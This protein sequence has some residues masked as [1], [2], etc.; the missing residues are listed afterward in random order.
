MALLP[1]ILSSELCGRIERRDGVMAGDG[2]GEEGE[3]EEEEE[4]TMVDSG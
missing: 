2:G 4:G 3:R 1:S